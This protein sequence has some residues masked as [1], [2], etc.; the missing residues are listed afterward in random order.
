MSTPQEAIPEHARSFLVEHH[1]ARTDETPR[2]TPLTGGVS[3]ELWRVDLDGG[4]I[5]VKGALARLKVAGEWTAPVSRNAVEWEW[6]S[7]AQG[8]MPDNVP[9]PLAHDPQRGL[10][11]MRY[12]PSIDY[13]VWKSQLLDGNVRSSVAADVGDLIGRLH[14][15][16]VLDPELP[17]RFSTDE[18]FHVL[19]IEPYL[20]TT[21]RAHSNL[22][23]RIHSLVT[24]TTSTRLA[25]VHGDVSP[26]NI[27]IGPNGPVLLDAECAWFGDPAFDLAFLLTHLALKMISQPADAA[28]LADSAQSL[29]RA[30]ET[31][32]NWEPPEAVLT[33]TAR[34]LPV[35]MLARV[36]GKSPVEYLNGGQQGVVRDLSSALLI[37]ASDDLDAILELVSR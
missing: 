31:Q 2:W 7:F 5:C 8:V 25:L 23:E 6:L 13:P 28:K 29:I 10:F 19:R 3:S 22:A 21:A 1:L 4:S 33:R 35:L 15:A 32:V 18:N 20:L 34:L 16:S 24:T 26:K 11:A 14:A 12:L 30:Y 36:D 9:E 17:E 27:L 37:A